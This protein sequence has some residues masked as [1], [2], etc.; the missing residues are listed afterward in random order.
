[1]VELSLINR[2]R[3]WFVKQELVI[4]LFKPTHLSL[5]NKA[6]IFRLYFFLIWRCKIISIRP[7]DVERGWDDQTTAFIVLM[8]SLDLGR[9]S[10]FNFYRYLKNYYSTPQCLSSASAFVFNKSRKRGEGQHYKKNRTITFR[11]RLWLHEK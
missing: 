8:S 10:I 2:I 9:G 7:T 6:H 4:K 5:N 3:L 11:K 1:L